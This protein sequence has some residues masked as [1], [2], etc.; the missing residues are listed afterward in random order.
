[1]AGLQEWESVQRD[2]RFDEAVLAAARRHTLQLRLASMGRT[3]ER[4]LGL[5]SMIDDAPLVSE[6]RPLKA[7]LWR[8]AEEAY[9]KM[10][11]LCS[12]I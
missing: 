1:M 6:R 11:E 4:T 7:T 2:G 5:R 3:T 8:V 9:K 12:Y 10:L